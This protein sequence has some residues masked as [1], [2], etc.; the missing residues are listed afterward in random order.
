M[1]EA[2]GILLWIIGAD[3]QS[4][5]YGFALMMAIEARLISVLLLELEIGNGHDGRVV[6]SCINVV[7]DGQECKRWIYW[8]S[9]YVSLFYRTVNVNTLIG[10]VFWDDAFR[11]AVDG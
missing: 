1:I 9:G 11:S 2:I 5:F 3:R 8:L 7:E 10:L 4:S 6:A